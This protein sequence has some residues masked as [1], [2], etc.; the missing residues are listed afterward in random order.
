MALV[1][2]TQLSDAQNIIIGL[3]QRGYDGIIDKRAFGYVDVEHVRFVWHYGK[4]DGFLVKAKFRAA[5]VHSLEKL[6]LVVCPD[7]L[8]R[9]HDESAILLTV[10][11]KSWSIKT[12]RGFES[13]FGYY[14]TGTG[15]ITPKTLNV[16]LKTGEQKKLVG[17]KSVIVIGGN[18]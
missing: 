9:L 6:G 15:A 3:L 14:Q 16:W 12:D 8:E 11:G 13:G 17:N 2:R 1:K 4:E 18:N 7:K 10:A 5:T